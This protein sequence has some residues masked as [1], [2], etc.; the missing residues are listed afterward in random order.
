MSAARRPRIARVEILFSENGAIPRA[1]FRSLALADLAVAHALKR[2]PP[3]SEGSYQ[4]TDYRI[5]WTDGRSITLRAD[6]TAKLVEK[7]A[8][9]GVLRH[10]AL[11]HAAYLAG[12]RAARLAST[13]RERSTN[14]EA[15]RELAE[16]LQREAVPVDLLRNAELGDGGE[17]TPTLLPDPVAAVV[18]MRARFAESRGWVRPT[19]TWSDRALPTK[20]R[21]HA[22]PATT[23]D[24]IRRAVNTVSIALTHDLRNLPPNAARHVWHYWRSVVDGVEILLRAPSASA[25]YVDNEGFWVR[26][27]P[28]LAERVAAEL[29]TRN[30]GPRAGLTFRPVGYTGEP[31]PQWLRELQDQAGVYVF[32]ERQADGS[33]PVVYVGMSAGRLYDTITRHLQ[34][35]RRAGSQRWIGMFAPR[36][37]DPG[38]TYERGRIFVAVLLTAPEDARAMELAL[39]AELSPRDNIDGAV[40]P[41]GDDSASAWDDDAPDPGA[42]AAGPVDAEDVPF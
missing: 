28:S 13:D 24:D 27:L 26:Q 21:L 9:V 19:G 2:E 40:A 11:A 8:G 33:T 20:V 36:D 1:V 5:V 15:G 29:V 22:H 6:L 31:Y 34:S 39:I 25:V 12:P 4:K 16:R 17:G 18:A 3:P 41:A 7:A 30:A 37:H 23:R 32:R 14:V 42:R 10:W 35:W 38:L